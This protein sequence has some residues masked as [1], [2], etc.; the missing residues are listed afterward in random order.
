MV[1]QPS[2]I[3]KEMVDK[4]IESVAKKKNPPA[5]P[6]VRFVSIAERLSVQT[7]HIGPYSEETENIKNLH[8]FA[9]IEGYS[10]SGK[11]H[12]IYLSDARK[13]APGKLRTIIRQPVEKA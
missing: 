7:L 13:T 12:E 4:A 5:H 10:L 11:H 2:H 8:R 3:T 9:E 1:M 6:K